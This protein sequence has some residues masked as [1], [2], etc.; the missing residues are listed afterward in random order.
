MKRRR[1]R[2]SK[3]GIQSKHCMAT[4]VNTSESAPV[5][6]PRL[7]PQVARVLASL[8]RR[9]FAYVW[10][11]GLAASLAFLGR[12]ILAFAALGLVDR[13]AGPCQADR[14]GPGR[15]RFSRCPVSADYPAVDGPDR[16]SQPGPVAGAAVQ[17]F[18]ESLLTAVEMGEEPGHAASFDRNLLAQTQTE[19]IDRL[20]GLQVGDVFRRGP[21]ARSLFGATAAIVSIAAL[22]WLAPNVYRTWAQRELDVFRCP[23]AAPDAFGH[24][25]FRRSGGSRS[26]KVPT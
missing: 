10:T 7:A 20:K 4:E 13:A 12:G 11:E 15:D 3:L 19:A 23:L 9:L 25:R 22:V 5:R 2:F 16:R 24:R 17:D 18:D 21:L 6:S 8:R 26:L 14:L 1:I